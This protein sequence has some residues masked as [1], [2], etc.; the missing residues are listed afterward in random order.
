MYKLVFA[1]NFWKV[2][3]KIT[4]GNLVLK[5]K[6]VKTLKLLAFDPKC[7]VLRA[8][9]VTTNRFGE[10]WAIWVSG[11]IRIIW[12]Y[13]ENNRL[14]ILVLSIGGHSGGGKAYKR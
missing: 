6:I 11:D 10:K 7:K 1:D 2:Y 12:D 8:H 13:D 3:K 4:K 14:T 9:K 5:K